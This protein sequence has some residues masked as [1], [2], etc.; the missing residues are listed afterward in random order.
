MKAI[1][2]N[3]ES[4][5]EKGSWSFLDSESDTE[6]QEE[7]DE[8]KEENDAYEIKQICIFFLNVLILYF[9]NFH[10]Y[11]FSSMILVMKKNPKMILTTL[12]RQEILKAMVIY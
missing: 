10:F 12:K 8:D 2:D 4:F 9:Y 5:F 3:A 6:N 7:K 1:T 11:L